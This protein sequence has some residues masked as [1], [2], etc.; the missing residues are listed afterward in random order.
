MLHTMNLRDN[1]ALQ[2]EL[3]KQATEIK[4]LREAKEQLQN[5]MVSFE[6]QELEWVINAVSGD[7]I[8]REHSIFMN[9]LI[10]PCHGL[11]LYF[12]WSLK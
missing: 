10:Y 4:D 11:L 1:A 5:E 2:V 9:H 8:I 3:M 6:E 12:Y 7:K